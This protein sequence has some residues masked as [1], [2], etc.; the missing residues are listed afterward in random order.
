MKKTP[1]FTIHFEPP[2]QEK[3]QKI[4]LYTHSQEINVTSSVLDDFCP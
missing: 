4:V 2:V 1:V 3:M